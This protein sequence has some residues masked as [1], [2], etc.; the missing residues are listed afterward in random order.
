MNSGFIKILRSIISTLSFVL[1][2]VLNGKADSPIIKSKTDTNQIRIGEQFHLNLS[3]IISPGT[4]ITFPFFADTF[5]HFEIVNKST[6]DTVLTKDKKELKL[7]QQ[8]TLTS[9]DS[10]YF[11]IPP[12]AFVVSESKEKSDTILTEALLITVVTVP[13]DTTKEIRALKN[14][15]DVPFPWTEYIIYLLIA[16]IIIAVI[17]YLFKR[18]KKKEIKIFAPKIPERPAHEIALEGLKKIEDEKLWQ[19]G[20]TKKYYSEVTDIL[21]QYI[22][23]RFSINAM[24]Q[25]TDETLNY[26]TNGFVGDEEKEK[27]RFILNL[28]DMVKFAKALSLP[29]ENESTMQ[30]AYA[31]INNTRQAVKEDFEKVEET[32]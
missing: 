18:F 20:F 24:E 1:I 26:F 4:Q 27:L 28:A 17:I 2:F 29:S 9:F 19:Q 32:K 23:R 13:V 5:N 10:G 16:G 15:I 25:T 6:I 31:F 22:E 8:L 11:V 30:F 14:I 3:A 21:R 12:M 7:Q